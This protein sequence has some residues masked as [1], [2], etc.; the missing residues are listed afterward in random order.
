MG[1][2]S[3]KTGWER[4]ETKRENNERGSVVTTMIPVYSRMERQRPME[5]EEQSVYELNILVPSL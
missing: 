4:E 1:E 5:R 2:R 3:S